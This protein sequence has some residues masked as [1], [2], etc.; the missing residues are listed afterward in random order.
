MK[1]LIISILLAFSMTGLLTPIASGQDTQDKTVKVRF[2]VFGWDDAPVD[3]NY[4]YRSKDTPILVIQDSRSVFYDY[5]GPAVISFYRLTK[6]SEGKIIR[7]I[8]CQANL[9]NA[10]SW[11]LILLAKNRDNPAKYDTRVLRDDL[12]S[13][14]SGSYAFSNFSTTPI[15]G[16]LGGQTFNLPPAGD[17]LLQPRTGDDVTTLSAVLVKMEGDQKVPVYTNNWAIQSARRT[18]VLIKASLESPSGL[19]SIRVVESTVFPNPKEDG[20]TPPD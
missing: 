17:K 10:G 14:P 1:S 8:A 15:I 3:L 16:S 7:E 12:T 20:I 4:A 2:R 18:R 9:D 5:T 19:I 11:P 6:N 13:F